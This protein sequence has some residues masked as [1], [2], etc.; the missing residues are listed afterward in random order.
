MSL[1]K[2]F[3]YKATL[4]FLRLSEFS[5]SLKEFDGAKKEPR[6][7]HSWGGV[8]GGSFSKTTSDLLQYAFAD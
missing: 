1:F 2:F 4:P 8:K 3:K 6:K 7:V 5:D